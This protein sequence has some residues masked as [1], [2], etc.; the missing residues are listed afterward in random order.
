MNIY[1]KDENI[2]KFL[3]EEPELA[4]TLTKILNH[5]KVI[6]DN[7][8][9]RSNIPTDARFKIHNEFLDDETDYIIDNYFITIAF[10]M[11]SIGNINLEQK[12]LFERLVKG[13]D[14]NKDIDTFFVKIKRVNKIDLYEYLDIIK[15]KKLKY[16]LIIDCMVIAG[17]GGMSKKSIKLIGD[18]ADILIVEKSEMDFLAE[19]SRCILT[20][21]SED[22]WDCKIN[23]ITC[24]DS[25]IADGYMQ[26][27]CTNNSAK[28]EK[29][30]KAFCNFETEIAMPLLCE[31]ANE[32]IYEAYPLLYW[33]YTDDSKFTSD[34]KAKYC[35]KMGYEHGDVISSILYGMFFDEK[36]EEEEIVEKFLPKLNELAREGNLY[37]EYTLGLLD[38]YPVRG[39][40]DNISAAKHFI[41]SY[42]KG[43]YRASFSMFLLF[44]DGKEP[45]SKDW[46]SIGIWGEQA[47]KYDILNMPFEVAYAYMHIDDYGCKDNN[48]QKEY[49]HEAINIWK[50]LI[51]NG[52][53]GSAVN[54][55]CMYR[56]GKGTAVN[57][58]KAFDYFK[59][60]AERGNMVGQCNLAASYEFGRGTEKNLEEAIKWYKKSAKQGHQIAIDSLEELEDLLEM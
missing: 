59:L 14:K 11:E 42:S 55:G 60:A 15:E 48:I 7:H 1:I 36:N 43:F 39:N 24:I 34:E 27:G 3:I 33:I 21:N 28:F 45:F 10:F 56:E 5:N 2:K 35:L 12:I 4:E 23:N 22:Y 49:Y 47:L 31:L 41:T 17:C 6:D 19:I 9:E 50:K 8:I 52:C 37:A 20:Q 53:V 51:K 40:V 16:R 57:L 18:Y 32:G 44:S 54:L 29:A 46:I 26:S 38:K 13:N 25:Y 30:S 58:E